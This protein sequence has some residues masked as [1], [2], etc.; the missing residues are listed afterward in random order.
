LFSP[1]PKPWR[2]ELLHLHQIHHISPEFI[3]GSP[4][5]VADEFLHHLLHLFF[6]RDQ[7]EGHPQA[8]S[9]SSPSIHGGTQ[10]DLLQR[11]PTPT[12]GPLLMLY[13]LS[14]SFL[15][16]PAL[17]FALKQAPQISSEPLGSHHHR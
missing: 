11:H 7:G 17:T 13:T 12:S 6:A 16:S 9:S 10:L 15:T 14:V 8:S 5:D 2:K 1:P 3:G 4:E